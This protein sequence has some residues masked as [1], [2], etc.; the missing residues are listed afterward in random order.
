MRLS[1][2]NEN[3]L[4]SGLNDS[5]ADNL[6]LLKNEVKAKLTL[7]YQS[8]SSSL[9]QPGEERETEDEQDE[10]EAIRTMSFWQV[11]K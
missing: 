1:K 7:A 5:T 3:I 11:C 9:T 6:P 10:L 2:H 4:Y 8:R